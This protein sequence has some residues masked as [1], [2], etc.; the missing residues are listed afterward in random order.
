[1]K[2]QTPSEMAGF[3]ILWCWENFSR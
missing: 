3:F 2:I 1:M